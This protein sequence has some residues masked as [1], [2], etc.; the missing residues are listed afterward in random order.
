MISWMD[1]ARQVRIRLA[2][3]SQEVP[4]GNLW[5]GYNPMTQQDFLYGLRGKSELARGRMISPEFDA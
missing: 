3:I 4:G 5:D 1:G 2:W